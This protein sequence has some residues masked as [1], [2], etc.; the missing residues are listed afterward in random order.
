MLDGLMSRWT[1]PFSCDVKVHRD[2][3]H[4]TLDEREIL[5][6]ARFHHFHRHGVD[7]GGVVVGIL[8]DGE[9]A[10]NLAR[11]QHLPATLRTT[12]SRPRL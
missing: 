1:I 8:Q 5:F 12:C 3:S 10:Q 11:L 2:L 9:A 7:L 4:P 6:F